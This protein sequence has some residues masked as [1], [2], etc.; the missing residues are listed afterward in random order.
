MSYKHLDQIRDLYESVN[1]IENR[2]NELVNEIITVIST[3]MFVEGYTNVAIKN[4]FDCADPVEIFEKY[5]EYSKDF[6]F[7]D[8]KTLNESVEH[9]LV[10][11]EE[12]IKELNLIIEKLGVGSLVRGLKK[13]A[14]P[15][16]AGIKTASRKALKSDNP[17]MKKIYAVKD[18]IKNK[19]KKVSTKSN[20]LELPLS[21][22]T[23]AKDTVSNTTKTVKDKSKEIF[24]KSKKVLGSEKTKKAIDK[25]KKTIGKI[26]KILKPTTKRG[27]V[28]R[29]AAGLGG[30]GIISAAGGDKKDKKPETKST[31]T[32]D[33]KKSETDTKEPRYDLSGVKGVDKGDAKSNTSDTKEKKT[34]DIGSQIYNNAVKISQSQAKPA[35]SKPSTASGKE[36]PKPRAIGKGKGEINP[37]SARGRMIAKNQERFGKDRIQKLR[38]KNAAFQAARKK[39]SGYSMDDFVKDFPDSNTAK[40]RAKRKKT[41][42]VMDYESYDAFDIVSNYLIDSNQVE[43]MDEALYVMTEMDAKTIQ[44][45]V[46]DFN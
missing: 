9:D 27:F 18:G 26:G 12:S 7:V 39:G 23:S 11:D 6:L 21:K 44:S 40:D 15:H 19:I 3:S 5:E 43:N 45:I 14:A 2:D 32:P 22:N 42:S 36:T 24:D 46:S 33:T 17:V 20:Q 4:Y 28:V 31:T 13:V 30:A 16:L 25:T 10:L 29:A 41:P 35:P 8:E 1:D 37:N 38:D 34:S